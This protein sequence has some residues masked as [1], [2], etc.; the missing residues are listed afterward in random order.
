MSLR[1]R[2]ILYIESWT[3]ILFIAKQVDSKIHIQG[4]EKDIRKLSY[5]RE[6]LICGNDEEQ[7]LWV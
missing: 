6:I 3:Q 7:F 1:M 2:K 4:E 5:P